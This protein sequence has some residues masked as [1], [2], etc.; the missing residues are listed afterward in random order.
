MPTHLKYVATVAY[1]IDR[2]TKSCSWPST[3]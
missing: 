3:K 2:I 1:E